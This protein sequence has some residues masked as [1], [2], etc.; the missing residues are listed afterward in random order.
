MDAGVD[1]AECGVESVELG[2]ETSSKSGA[3]LGVFMTVTKRSET[4]VEERSE[5]G[6]AATG[7][8][9]CER[10]EP[11][12]VATVEEVAEVEVGRAGG[13]EVERAERGGKVAEAGKINV[14]DFG[15]A[16]DIE[17]GEVFEAVEVAA[18]KGE[19]VADGGDLDL[20]MAEAG[21]GER[22][23]D[24]AEGEG[25]GEVEGREA[26]EV[27]EGLLKSK[28]NKKKK[29]KSKLGKQPSRDRNEAL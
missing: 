5:R 18:S 23:E 11:F 24:G 7:V 12:E 14:A 19:T 17:R 2:E 28:Q 29:R 22:V 6:K 8:K 16:G 20:E 15:R 26:R 9:R 25:G 21:E 10:T 13:F 3:S 4:K 27:A 1:E